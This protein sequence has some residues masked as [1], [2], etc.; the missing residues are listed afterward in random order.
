MV[1][2]LSKLPL[3][4]PISEDDTMLTTQDIAVINDNMPN[5]FDVI[6]TQ[7]KSKNWTIDFFVNNSI[8][9]LI[10]WTGHQKTFKTFETV[11]TCIEK[12]CFNARKITIRISTLRQEATLVQ[13]SDNTQS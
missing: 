7:E 3:K 4:H 11:L 1:L 5:K 6:I 8:Q 10:T 12:Y 13:N 9:Q 2:A